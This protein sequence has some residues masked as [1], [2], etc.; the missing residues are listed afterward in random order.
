MKQIE[1]KQHIEVRRNVKVWV[2]D[3]KD[4]VYAAELLDKA[5]LN[6]HGTSVMPS[7]IEVSDEG[8]QYVCE[9]GIEN[10]DGVTILHGEE[11][12]VDHG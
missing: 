9:T 8:W 10:A 12:D 3:D 5:P 1:L 2:P 6:L 4:E 11:E 7:S